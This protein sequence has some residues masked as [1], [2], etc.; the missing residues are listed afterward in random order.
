MSHSDYKSLSEGYLDNTRQ[1]YSIK[2][3]SIENYVDN[4][5]YDL[6]ST[7]KV[8]CNDTMGYWGGTFSK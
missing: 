3:Q 4:I 7:T 6:S 8:I 2:S 5:L 1:H